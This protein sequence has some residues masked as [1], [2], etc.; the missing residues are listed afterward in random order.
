MINQKKDYDLRGI[1]KLFT[2]SYFFVNLSERK[3]AVG[4]LESTSLEAE[5]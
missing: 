3:A 1:V 2:L 5:L 4:L